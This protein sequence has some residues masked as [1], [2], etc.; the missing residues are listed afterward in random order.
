MTSD[1]RAFPKVWALTA[2]QS[3]TSTFKDVAFARTKQF[4]SPPPRRRIDRVGHIAA[5]AGY[6]AIVKRYELLGPVPQRM[7]DIN[8][9]REV[10]GRTAYVSLGPR[11]RRLQQRPS[12]GR[13]ALRDLHDGGHGA[14]LGMERL[15]RGPDED[16]SASA[17]PEAEDAGSPTTCAFIDA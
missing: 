7:D 4:E 13:A 2:T 1:S 14:R 17:A 6:P 9:D 16:M 3:L 15:A 5:D 8:R 12:A 11:L 10:P